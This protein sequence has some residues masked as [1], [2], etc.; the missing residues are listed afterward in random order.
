MSKIFNVNWE[1]LYGKLPKGKYRIIK[2]VLSN[3]NKIED[4][5]VAGEFIIE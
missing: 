5:Y 3:K 4:I 1:S 2:S